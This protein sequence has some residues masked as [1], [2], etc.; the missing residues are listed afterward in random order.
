MLAI[1]DPASRL[2]PIVSGY[3]LILWLQAPSSSSPGCPHPFSKANTETKALLLL[4]VLYTLFFIFSPLSSFYDFNHAVPLAWSTFPNAQL[5]RGKSN[6][7]LK[8]HLKCYLFQKASGLGTEAFHHWTNPALY[9][10]IFLWHLSP[11]I[12]V[13]CLF[14]LSSFLYL[15][16]Q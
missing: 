3:K 11:Y 6:L 2:V 10:T 9:S 13:I 5:Y 7:H 8:V 14:V 12:T 4:T 15:R 1:S 16:S